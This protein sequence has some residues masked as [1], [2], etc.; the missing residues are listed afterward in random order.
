MEMEGMRFYDP[1]FYWTRAMRRRRDYLRSPYIGQ[2]LDVKY[3]DLVTAPEPT[4]RNVCAFLGEEFETEMLDWRDLTEL[5]PK[6]ERSIHTKLAE[7]LR[8]EAVDVWQ[9]KLSGLQCFAVECCLQ[10]DLRELGYR[11][12]FAGAAWRPLLIVCQWLFLAMAPLLARGI[13]Y[14]QR[15]NYLPRTIFL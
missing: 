15:R 3:E 6:R 9:K 10:R 2:I 14:L 12:R 11:L 8:R 4:L 13:P 7:P 1:N 5:V